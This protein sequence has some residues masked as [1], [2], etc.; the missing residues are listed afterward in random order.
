MANS[1]L[2]LSVD[3]REYDSKLKNAA[4]GIQHLAKRAH[5]M[6]G[7]FANLDKA[8]VDF[9]KNL[10]YMNTSARTAGGNVRELETAYK[11]LAATYNQLNEYEKKDEGGKALATS[12]EMLKQRAQEARSAMNE[13]TKSLADNGQEGKSSST[14]L[15]QLA[16]KFTINFDAVTLMSKGLGVASQALD[17]AKEAFFSSETNVDE[18]GR[19]VEATGSIYQSFLQSLNNSD[20]SGFITG[21]GRV[22][23]AAKDAYNAIDELNTRMTI[24]NP[25]RAKLQARQT[26]LKATIR[27]N[28]ADSAAGKAAQAE[29]K[30]MEPLLV[31][32][33]QTEGQMNLDAFKAQVRKKLAEGNIKL[34]DKEMG[35][36]LATMSS[37]RLFRQFRAN[38]RG[39]KGT[40]VVEN[41]YSDSQQTIKYDTRNKNQK[42]LDL[43]TDEWRQQNSG[44]LTAYY[45][46][47]SQA[48]SVLLGD[49][50]YVKAAKGG[51][52]GGKTG[53]G[54]GNTTVKELTEEQKLQQ[55]INDLVQQG[56]TMDEKGRAA[57]RVKIAA[58]QDQL[59]TYKDIENELRGI[60]KKETEIKPIK[61]VETAMSKFE[62]GPANVQSMQAY[63]SAMQ[64]EMQKFDLGSE[65]YNAFDAKLK[66]GN[67]LSQILQQAMESGVQGAN[68]ENVA[69]TIKDRMLQGG[70]MNTEQ[71][72]ALVDEINASIKDNDLK[73]KLEID[74]KGAVTGVT[75]QVAEMTKNWKAAGAAISQVGSAMS[76]IEDPA[77]KVM[78]TIA[79]AIATM[80]LS[81]AE[82][83]HQAA[84]N[85]ANAGWGWIAFA[86]T[87]LATMI[88]S[89]SAIHS[90]TGYASGGI[91]DGSRGGFVGG[92]AY[93]GDQVGNVR[94][95]SGELVLSRSQQFALASQLEGD[96]N[97]GTTPSHPYVSGEMIFLGLN[98][99]LRRSGRG[100]IVTSR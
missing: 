8:E 63:L 43:F 62:G 9:I 50:R 10:G 88:S 55:Q 70:V 84:M 44:Y 17:V 4:E 40:K 56:M 52:G 14:I 46:A 31:K 66:E 60:G 98:N 90:A 48:N 97:Q 91:V 86:A 47:E 78:G 33:F 85:P 54:G 82:A 41:A 100:E 25:E 58:L 72:K 74:G 59:Q 68:L 28:G 15:D 80:A 53:K 49:A 27:R 1:I 7:E 96:G 39:S 42:L 21:I 22:I 16:S 73:L 26:Q 94:L 76:Q 75:T 20:F 93:S 19:T 37:D 51:T 64:G 83:S 57:Q 36:F 18:W 5:D 38:A 87:G 89:I 13:A 77:A 30:Q 61:P 71:I 34:S 67:T 69:Q 92:S 95:D 65:F 32:S 2:K 11:N 3:T 81:Y 79:Q 45:N 6:Q 23:M 29:L 24:I 99:Y 12:L 35:A